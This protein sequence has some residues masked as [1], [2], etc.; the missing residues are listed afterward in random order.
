MTTSAQV[1]GA[2]GNPI[3]PTEVKLRALVLPGEQ[4][5]QIMLHGARNAIKG[6][7]CLSPGRWQSSRHGE[8]PPGRP[9]CS[10]PLLRARPAQR[11]AADRRVIGKGESRLR[12][13]SGEACSFEETPCPYLRGHLRRRFRGQKYGWGS[14]LWPLTT[15][16]GNVQGLGRVCAYMKNQIS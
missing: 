7:N 15:P 10:T 16:K 3:R 9:A 13:S 6:C 14:G 4:R 8:R 2:Y 12:L 5:G 1:Y 11:V